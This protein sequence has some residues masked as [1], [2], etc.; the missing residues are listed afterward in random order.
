MA[1]EAEE[2]VECHAVPKDGKIEH[3]PECPYGLLDEIKELFRTFTLDGQRVEEPQAERSFLDK[4]ILVDHEPVLF[5]GHLIEWGLW[6]ERDHN[7]VVK[8][9]VVGQYRVSTIFLGMDH[10]WL[11]SKES[12]PILFE[13]MVFVVEGYESNLEI[14]QRCC[15][16][17]E[18]VAQ[19]EAM[20]KKFR[21]LISN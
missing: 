16:W 17:D 9:E 10:N 12:K 20:M 11:R 18:A 19:H 15:T 1:P 6:M 2:C 8:Q 7:R 14:R 13:T 4:Y 21:S 5:E 3:A